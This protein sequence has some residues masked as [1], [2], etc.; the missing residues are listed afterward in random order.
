MNIK[1]QLDKPFFKFKYITSGMILF[2]L[3]I[4]I[5][6]SLIIVGIGGGNIGIKLTFIILSGIAVLISAYD[7]GSNDH[8]KAIKGG[9]IILFVLI[10]T[11]VGLYLASTMKTTVPTGVVIT[12]ESKKYTQVIDGKEITSSKQFKR[13]EFINLETNKKI[14]YRT[15]EMDELK[16]L[17]FYKNVIA[18]ETYIEYIPFFIYKEQIK[19]LRSE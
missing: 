17:D 18:F 12:D 2:S 9:L 5:V 4:G 13:V 19:Y 15:I 1:S 11:E 8:E 7:S 14:G 6:L 16:K 3:M 10:F